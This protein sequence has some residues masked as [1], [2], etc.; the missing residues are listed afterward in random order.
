MV[1][2]NGHSARSSEERRFEDMER[3][4][5]EAAGHELKLKQVVLERCLDDGTGNESRDPRR[6]HDPGG[7][8][9]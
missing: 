7:V 5:T 6:E 8:G 9:I 1:P 2:S 4:F 3:A